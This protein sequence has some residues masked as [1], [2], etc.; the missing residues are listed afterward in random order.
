MA[1]HGLDLTP[2]YAIGVGHI[3]LGWKGRRLGLFEGAH[4]RA[5]Y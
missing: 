4:M 5:R 3:S 1:R 2:R